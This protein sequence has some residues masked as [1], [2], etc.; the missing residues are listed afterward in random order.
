MLS[1]WVKQGF[2]TSV[3]TLITKGAFIDRKIDLR[4]TAIPFDY[5]LSFASVYAL[6][7]SS[8]LVSEK[9]RLR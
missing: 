8:A 3:C 5:D 2:R 4:K 6:A 1:F 7:T 9:S